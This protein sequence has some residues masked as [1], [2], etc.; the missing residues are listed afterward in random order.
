MPY[1]CSCDYG[2]YPSVYRSKV[3]KCRKP[4]KCEECAGQILP[5][6]T[7]EYAFYVYDGYSSSIKTCGY[8][9][10]IR[11]WLRNNVPCLCI[12]HGNQDEE[13]RAAIESAYERAGDEVTGLWFGYQRRVIER[14]RFNKQRHG[15]ARA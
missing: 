2:D 8:C 15:G 11:T 4:A 6:D 7:Y 9:H 13:N 3:Q 10:D 12:V 14:L 5:G 1:D